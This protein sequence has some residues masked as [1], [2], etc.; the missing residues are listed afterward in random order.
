MKFNFVT[1]KYLLMWYLCCYENN[2]SSFKNIKLELLNNYRRDVFLL[3]KEKE[4]ILNDLNDYIPDDDFLYNKIQKTIEFKQIYTKNKQDRVKYLSLFDFNKREITKELNKIIKYNGKIVYNICIIPGFFDE[5]EFDF[6]RKIV[7][8]GKNINEK[9]VIGFYIF[10]IYKIMEYEYKDYKKND[11]NI[12]NA[13][14]ELAIYNELYTKVSNKNR[15]NFGQDNLK[16]I[17]RDIFP[18]FFMYLGI[19]KEK[20]N[21]LN[22]KA[23]YNESLKLMDLYSFINYVIKNKG[24]IFSENYEVL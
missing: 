1:N 11:R 6:D 19:S 7:I 9:E 14:L 23:E 21:S 16:K 20:Y 17:K 2:N 4:K 10:I 8:L 3:F 22:L 12:V 5:V 13:I 24:T 15:Y 18:Y